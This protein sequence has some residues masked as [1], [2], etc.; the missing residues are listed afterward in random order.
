[1]RHARRLVITAVMIY[2]WSLLVV[3]TPLRA[4]DNHSNALDTLRAKVVRAQP[5]D[6][7]FLYA[8]LV[9]QL[10]ELAG[11]QFSAGNYEE[12][13]ATVV[14]VRQYADEMH[15]HVTDDGR[16]VKDAE[17]LMRH[18]IFRMKGILR[19]APFEGRTTLQTTLEQLDKVQDQLLIQVFKR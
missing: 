17:L 15:L 12:A 19:E 14:L 8:K 7:C 18:S 6:K 5:R 16:K 1:V 4:L 11:Q 9:N 2:A 3:G 13:S 10:T